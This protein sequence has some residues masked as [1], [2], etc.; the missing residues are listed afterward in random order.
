MAVVFMLTLASGGLAY[1]IERRK[2]DRLKRPEDGHD[3]AEKR[4]E[5]WGFASRIGRE[6]VELFGMEY[7]HG[8]ALFEDLGERRTTFTEFLDRF[9]ELPKGEQH[10][11]L[12]TKNIPARPCVSEPFPVRGRVRGYLTASRCTG[13]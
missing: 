1:I 3:R 13:A 12:M 4:E 11:F 8:L 6:G 2:S 10:R 9:R 7:T 5:C